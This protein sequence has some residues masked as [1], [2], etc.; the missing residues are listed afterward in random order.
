MKPASIYL[1]FGFILLS[2]SYVANKFLL[3]FLPINFLSAFKLLFSGLV[4]L[5]VFLA[6]YSQNDFLKRVKEDIFN[7]AFI[8]VIATC[9][10]YFLKMYALKNLTSAQATL[11]GSL[12]PFITTIYS[13]FLWNERI[14]FH[15]IFGIFFGFISVVFLFYSDY[16][17]GEMFF[18]AE[19]FL[20][21][22][23]ALFAVAIGR[24][25]W[26]RTQRL[27]FK[28]RYSLIEMNLLISLGGGICSLI[29]FYLTESHAYSFHGVMNK[30]LFVL[31]LYSA[32]SGNIFAYYIYTYYLKKVPITLVSYAGLII[33]ISCH[34]LS[35]AFLSE[36][37]SKNFFVSIGLMVLGY[38]CYFYRENKALF[39]KKTLPKERIKK[40]ESASG[41]KQSP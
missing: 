34:F 2:S 28:N 21:F 3:A 37:L 41:I 25:G 13:Y 20:G 35:W 32:I 12:D 4:F 22:I 17:I 6:K 24:Y 5:A 1:I 16:L 29:V 11:I 38:M 23:Y 39:L 9:L 30:K 7:I 26:I 31:L 36:Q 18:R 8:C 10:P 19:C 27:L 33:P 14:F 15:K 40:S